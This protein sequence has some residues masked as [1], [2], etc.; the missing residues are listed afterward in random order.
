MH[1]FVND[2]KYHKHTTKANKS[3]QL[4]IDSQND[5]ENNQAIYRSEREVRN[6]CNCQRCYIAQ[7]DRMGIKRHRLTQ[8]NNESNQATHT[9]NRGI[10]NAD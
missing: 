2:V 10:R 9:N 6:A 5:T 1:I 7:A 4:T 3:H 8:T